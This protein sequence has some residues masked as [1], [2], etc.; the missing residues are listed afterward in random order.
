MVKRN[1][2]SFPNFG[3]Q[4]DPDLFCLTS[5]GIEAAKNILRIIAMDIDDLEYCPLLPNIVSIL[6]HHLSPDDTMACVFIMIR[7]SLVRGSWLYFPTHLD[8]MILFYGSFNDMVSRK[9]PKVCVFCEQFNVFIY[10]RLQPP[11]PQ[12]FE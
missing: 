3:G 12:S 2:S 4:F 5:D 8:D 9:L 1:A 7:K 6:L 10:F 11:G